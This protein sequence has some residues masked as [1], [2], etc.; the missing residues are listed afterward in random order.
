M[1]PRLAILSLVLALVACTAGVW[2]VRRVA[3]AP[4]IAPA[5]HDVQVVELTPG[6]RQITYSVPRH[7]DGWQTPVARQLRLSDW[8]VPADQ[9]HWGGTETITTLAVYERTSRVWLFEIHER[10][11]LLGDHSNAIIKISY[12]VVFHWD[13]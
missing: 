5:A 8:R 13:V 11:E 10:A 3:T 7:G 4:F 9:Y 6:R 12:G 1:L 2:S